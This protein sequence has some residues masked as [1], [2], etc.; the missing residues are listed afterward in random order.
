MLTRSASEMD[1]SLNRRNRSPSVLQ[2]FADKF[3]SPPKQRRNSVGDGP[4]SPISSP[5][6]TQMYP[7]PLPLDNL[8]PSPRSLSPKEEGRGDFSPRKGMMKRL[9][10]NTTRILPSMKALK[11]RNRSQSDTTATDGTKEAEVRTRE[12]T[13]KHKMT[14]LIN[15]VHE[16]RLQ[17]Y[18]TITRLTSTAAEDSAWINFLESQLDGVKSGCVPSREGMITE[19]INRLAV[20]EQECREQRRKCTEL[21]MRVK[22][23]EGQLEKKSFSEPSTPILKP[24]PIFNARHTVSLEKTPLSS[25]FQSDLFFPDVPTQ[26]PS[27]HWSPLTKRNR[28]SLVAR[29]D[30]YP[31][32]ASHLKFHEGD[33]L[34]VR[35]RS[36]DGWWTAED[37]A[38][39]IGKVPRNYVVD[40]EKLPKETMK[41][42]GDFAPDFPG[43]VRLWEGCRVNVLRREDDWWIVEVDESIGYAPSNFLEAEKSQ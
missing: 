3:R 8:P 15:Q 41:A 35:D 37:L 40:L 23:L 6:E 4:I 17:T 31:G 14:D 5:N 29:C 9:N 22:E 19:L 33:L 20:S 25:S 28:P 39:N 38:G 13:M 7:P 24:K 10:I 18:D 36:A 21:T 34:F 26:E 42:K 2:S 30:Y 43:D 1:G 27:K 32:V 12:D 16:D 11:F